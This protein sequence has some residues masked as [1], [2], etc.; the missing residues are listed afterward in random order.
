MTAGIDVAG[1]RTTISPE[2]V[3]RWI[4]LDNAATTR[5]DPAVVDAM[6][7]FFTQSFGNP[8]SSHDFGRA[9]AST[10]ALARRQVQSLIGAAS[11]DEIVFTAGATE[12]NNAALRQ[13]MRRESRN[14]VVVSAVEHP[15]ILAVVAD[16]EKHHGLVV[17][18]IGVDAAGRLDM[19]AYRDALNKRT[20]LVSMM[21]AN[22]QTGT[23]F[24]IGELAALAHEVGAIFHTDAV[25]AAGKIALNVQAGEID[26]LSLSAHKLHGPK[27][28]GALY[29]RKGTK[30]R[31]L[32]RGGRQ[33]RARRAG[34]ENVPGIIGFGMAARLAKERMATDGVQISALRERLER[35]I[36]ARINSCLILGDMD[37]R[38]PGTSCTAF[39]G[40]DGE[41][42][43]H[44]LN[45]SSIAASAGSACTAGNMEPSHVVRA[46]GVPF[47]AAHGVVRFSLSRETSKDDID[48][49]LTVLPAI[50][51]QARQ[52]SPFAARPTAAE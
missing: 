44:R 39:D 5:T 29:V 12:A 48:R 11:E 45:R 50:V 6:L 34:T 51:A 1:K 37:N 25:Q 28:V 49:V 47:T 22:N 32:M 30:F 13:A 9:A 3:T 17:H 21:A 33:E 8:S 41:E 20:A 27:G 2:A 43:L 23:V 15:A 19:S 38:V 40:A 10:M 36:E 24:P 7:P 46:M 4:Y 18:R 31:A 26:L 35:G 42:I 14:E 52:N 16:L